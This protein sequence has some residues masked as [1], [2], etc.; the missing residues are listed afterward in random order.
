VQLIS[1]SQITTY[2]DEC[3]RKWAWRSVA[4]V[5]QQELHPAAA[6]GIEVDDEQLQPY[7]TSAKTFDYTR[8]SGYIAASALAFLPEPQLPGLEVQRHFV[9]PSPTWI[10]GPNGREHIGFGY[11][12]YIDLWVPD[13]TAMPGLL[14]EERDEVEG[15]VLPM[16]VVSDFKTTSNLRWQKSKATLSTDVQAMLYAMHALFVT[17]APSVDLAWI[18]M[19][20]KQ[21]RK[22]R[23]T[24]LRVNAAHV[25]E[26][27]QGINKIATEMLKVRRHL[28]VLHKD[29]IMK[30]PLDL[31]PNPLS[32][33]S[34]NG[35]PYRAHCN[36]SPDLNDE[37]PKELDM[38]NVSNGAGGG[39]MARLRAQRAAALG[40]PV[41]ASTEPTP[42]PAPMEVVGINPP[43]AKLVETAAT[44]ESAAQA[45]VEPTAPKK[46]G[47]PAG[48]KNKAK[49]EAAPAAVAAPVADL[50]V[51][52]DTPPP[53]PEAVLACIR[54][55]IRFA[56]S[57]P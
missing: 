27:F 56:R 55:L 24:Y 37:F 49:E 13:S 51:F 54:T 3:K 26:Q 42:A 53:S 41:P 40:A 31:E 11:Q 28:E 45:A 35:C 57:V 4:K 6:L 20:T 14:D 38:A 10:D 48:S 36:L 17:R 8:D 5:E 43:E 32:C 21:A 19:Q 29:D 15:P 18:Y 7:L 22:A 25:A 33:D 23:R 16:P 46:A 44:L 2:R 39:V 12:G 50:P 30:A 1:A 9:M 34:Y 52:E 47:R